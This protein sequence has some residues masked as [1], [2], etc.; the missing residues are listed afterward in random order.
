MKSFI[1]LSFA[2]FVN[3]NSGHCKAAQRQVFVAKAKGG[4][5]LTILESLFTSYL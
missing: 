3:E 4:T 1:L 2:D 5:D